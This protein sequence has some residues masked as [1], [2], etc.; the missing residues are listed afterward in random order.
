MVDRFF[1]LAG[2]GGFGRETMRLVRRSF[3]NLAAENRCVF[4]E[5][6]P[7]APQINGHEVQSIAAFGARA[8]VARLFAVAIANGQ[9]RKRIAEELMLAGAIPETLIAPTA[10]VYDETEIG[11]GA[12]I[13]ENSMVTANARTGIHFHLNVFS[14]VAHDCVI[15]DYVT[16]G[17]GVLCCGNVHVGDL[18]YIGAGAI[19]REGSRLEPMMIGEGALIG[20]GAVVTRPVPPGAVV[21]GN[22]AR[23]LCRS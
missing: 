7:Q 19:I 4:L 5:S 2:A 21:V 13:C 18:A 10:I 3:P 17:P 9:A 14:Y 16:F 1:G 22:P 6:E 20:M 12:I 23:P 15:G 8:N 11:V